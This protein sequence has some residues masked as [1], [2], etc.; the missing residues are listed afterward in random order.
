MNQFKSNA[1]FQLIRRE[2][3]YVNDPTDRGGETNYGITVKTARA[4]GYTGAMRDL[5]YETA[6]KIYEAIYWQPLKLDEI[7][8]ISEALVTQLF[9]FCV[10]SGAGAAGRSLQRALNVLNNAQTLYPDLAEDG[11]LGSKSLAALQAYAAH[12]KQTGLKVM[13]EAIRAQRIT[14]CIDIAANDESQEKYS[15]GWLQRIVN[16]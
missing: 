8:Q 10:N 11:V 14:F 15:F 3:G 5:P 1:I 16:L 9:D 2:G 6:V 7:Q 12:R 13:V 4:H